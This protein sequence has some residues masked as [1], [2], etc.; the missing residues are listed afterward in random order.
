MGGLSLKTAGVFQMDQIDDVRLG[1]LED[2]CNNCAEELRQCG[3]GLDHFRERLMV[4][5]R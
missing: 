4:S 5:D 2:P 1:D 3:V